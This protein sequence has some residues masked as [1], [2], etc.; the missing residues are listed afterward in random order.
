MV[1]CHKK[2]GYFCMD[3]VDRKQKVSQ[4]FLQQMGSLG[5]N[6]ELQAKTRNHGGPCANLL[7]QRRGNS[8]RGEK[9]VGRAIT[10]KNFILICF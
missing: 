1:T 9:E 5:N 10:H 8:Y 6:K 7:K 4:M 3:I 2:Y